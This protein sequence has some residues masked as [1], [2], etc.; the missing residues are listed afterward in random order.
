MTIPASEIVDKAQALLSRK[1]GG[2]QRFTETQRLEGTGTATVLRARLAP[3]AFLQQRSV[4]VKYVP[5]TGDLFDDAALLR[6]IA[7][8]QFTT[9]LSE[10]VRPG[11]YMLAHD[12]DA[13]LM[14]ISD[15]GD[16]DRFS[17]LL[18]S[19]DPEA[20]EQML[21]NLGSA[22]GRMHAGTAGSEKSFRTLL[23]RMFKQY[24]ELE[25]SRD[26]RDR[27]IGPATFHGAT[28]I[29]NAGIRVPECVAA[30]AEDATTRLAHS[31]SR[32]FTPFDLSPDNIIVAQRTEFLDYEW[33]DFR[34]VNYDLACVIGGF[35]Q[36]AGRSVI[37]DEE[38]D[39]FLK[40]WVEEVEDIWPDTANEA[41]LHERITAALI[42][43]ALSSVSVLHHGSIGSALTS[44]DD[45]DPE[46]S[47]RLFNSDEDFTD[48][49]HLVR[50]D[51]YETFSSLARYARQGGD[52][53][54]EVVASFAE[55]VAERVKEPEH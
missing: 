4:V 8:Y 27:S 3:Q 15:S 9:S 19:N 11:P 21:R 53:R 36:Y 28:L 54:F 29:R 37:S 20:R 22:L 24:P 18:E 5:E 35:P 30:L 7:A 51:F 40:A 25:P 32:A 43:W 31:R 46:T 13:R 41:H 2:G 34:D 16:G 55:E 26:L 52:N 38:G 14:V 47:T 49:E 39:A 23:N 10:N 42:S 50:R 45:D 48:A 6:E 44:L 1:F 17:E 12:M 33:A